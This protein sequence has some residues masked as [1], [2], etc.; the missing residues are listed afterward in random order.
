MQQLHLFDD[1]DP[2]GSDTDTLNELRKSMDDLDAAFDK[3]Y[4]VSDDDNQD[5]TLVLDM[6]ARGQWNARLEDIQKR[7]QQ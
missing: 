1:R 2:S 4:G 6:S 5:D 3:H 7:G